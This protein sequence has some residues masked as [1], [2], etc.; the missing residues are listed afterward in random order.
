MAEAQANRAIVH[1]DLDAFYA[2][3][4]QQRDPDRLRGK[5]TAVMQVNH[6]LH[7]PCQGHCLARC[8]DVAVVEAGL[9]T[10]LAEQ[11]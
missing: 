2:Q 6:A 8:S 1:V 4:E 10:L 5:P 3:V 7:S 11:A 9:S